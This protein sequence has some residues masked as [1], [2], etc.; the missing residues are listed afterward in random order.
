MLTMQRSERSLDPDVGG[1]RS[2]AGAREQTVH[3][4]PATRAKGTSI[5]RL[6]HLRDADSD[7]C[8]YSTDV[9]SRLSLVSL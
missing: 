4:S 6:V 2:H 7:L 1:S 5:I 9:T 3:V 8:Y